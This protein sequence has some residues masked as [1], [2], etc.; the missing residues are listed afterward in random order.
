M[1]NISSHKLHAYE[2]DACGDTSE[3]YLSFDELKDECK[4]EG[5]YI[6]KSDDTGEWEHYCPD[7]VRRLPRL[8]S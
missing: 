3:E 7:C 4:R 2:C 5:W 6:R 1:A 8:K